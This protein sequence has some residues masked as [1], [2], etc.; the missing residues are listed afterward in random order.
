MHLFKKEKKKKTVPT[1][2]AIFFFFV[3]DG[4]ISKMIASHL[5]PSTLVVLKLL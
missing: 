3:S 5:F 1:D 2:D 4:V